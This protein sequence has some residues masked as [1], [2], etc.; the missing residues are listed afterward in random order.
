MR[1]NSAL[2]VVVVGDDAG[3]SRG[4]DVELLADVYSH[5]KF[6]TQR[7][8]PQSLALIVITNRV[9]FILLVLA[10]YTVDLSPLYACATREASV[11]H[12][13][14]GCSF[15]CHP[16]RESRSCFVTHARLTCIIFNS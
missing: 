3:I 1:I 8:D 16:S 7:I 11:S 13:G 4:V 14:K 2:V 12:A 6:L 9:F 15:G 10:K 5:R